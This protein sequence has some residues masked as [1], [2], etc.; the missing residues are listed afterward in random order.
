MLRGRWLANVAAQHW[1]SLSPTSYAPRR[2]SLAS[3]RCCAG[4]NNTI[5]LNVVK[6][7]RSMKIACRAGC[8]YSLRM[9]V[10]IRCMR[11]GS[12][13]LSVV[14]RGRAN[15]L[16]VGATSDSLRAYRAHAPDEPPEHK[17]DPRKVRLYSHTPGQ[18]PQDFLLYCCIDVC[19]PSYVF[20]IFLDKGGHRLTST[21]PTTRR[22]FLGL[23]AALCETFRLGYLIV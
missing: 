5:S 23:S 11:I 7:Y 8:G 10:M 9:C 2:R 15:A 17:Q 12:V 1:R 20:R 18:S 4:L 21:P 13:E 3:C 6:R 19:K 16:V 14:G 22:C